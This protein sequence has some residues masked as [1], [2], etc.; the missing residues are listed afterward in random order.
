L[1]CAIISGR[2]KNDVVWA[3]NNEDYVFFF[4]TYLN[5]LPREEGLRG[6]VSFTYGSPDSFI[7]GG[8][9]EDGL[10]FDFNALPEIPASN[11]RDWGNRKKFPGVA[12]R[13]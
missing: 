8:F 10:F 1:H 11:R 13:S 7:Q 2:T 4:D 12:R 9:N 3:G 6:A 5:V